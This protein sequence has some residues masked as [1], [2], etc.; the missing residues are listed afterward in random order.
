MPKFFVKSNG[1]LTHYQTTSGPFI[2]LNHFVFEGNETSSIN[3]VSNSLEK[4]YGGDYFDRMIER[5]RNVTGIPRIKWQMD[6]AP[7]NLNRALHRKIV[8]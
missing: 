8:R 4:M 6:I 2:R 5:A 3:D 7:D 1:N